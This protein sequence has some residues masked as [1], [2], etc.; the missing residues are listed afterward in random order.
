MEYR[1]EDFLML[2]GIQHFKFCRSRWALIH[3]EQQW[4]ENLRTIDGSIMHENAHD[5]FLN[6]NRKGILIRRGMNI[7]SRKM[8]ISGECDVVEFHKDDSGI[9]L[10][11][12]DGLW[13][14]YPVE[15]KRGKPN[16]QS[17]D[18]LQLCAQALC[19]EEML[20]CSI[21]V[22]ALYF[23]EIR[24]RVEVDFTQ[25][26]REEVHEVTYQMHDLYSKNRTP[27]VKPTKSCNACS[28]KDLCLPKLLG[29]RSVKQY[30]QS[31]LGEI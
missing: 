17:G 20:C 5:K 19:L 2:S 13:R 12:T 3:I 15:Y 6:E 9:S 25:K 28:L 30:I 26:L 8:G 24:R 16:E 27:K 1:E 31:N 7:H 11:G 4:Q 18:M 21:D 10:H 14:P 23:G 22:G 29:K